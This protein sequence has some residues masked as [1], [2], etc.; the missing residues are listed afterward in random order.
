[1]AASFFAKRR[2]F[3]FILAAILSTHFLF[4]AVGR[5]FEETNEATPPQAAFDKTIAP[6][7][8]R[9]CLD[10]HNRSELAGGLD[11]SDREKALAGGDS[12][13]VLVPG[14]PA[15]SLLW[16]RIADGEMPPKTPLPPE[17]RALLKT[18]IAE[19]GRWGTNPI[20]PFRFTT[21]A[22]AGYDWWSLQPLVRPDVPRLQPKS[23]APESV[24][25]IDAFVRV[26]LAEH[27]LSPSAAADKR[28][29][30][31]RLSFDLLGLPP[32]PEETAAFLADDSADAYE[33]FVDRLLASP[34]YGQRWARHWLD[35]VRFG[36]SQG[37]ERDKLRPNAWRY[38]DW[39]VAAF[40]RDMPY[41]EF[42]RLQLAGDV[43]RPGD[44]DAII[45]T[46]FL[47]AGAFDEVGQRQQ[48]AAMKAVVRQDELEDILGT[49]GQTFLGLTV[50]CARCHD[51]KFDPISQQE[52]Y[53]MSAALAGVRHGE[54]KIDGAGLARDA[55]VR[56]AALQTRIETLNGRRAAITEPIR[57]RLLAERRERQK[58]VTPP[59]PI[60]RW[61]FDADLK[62]GIGELH[63]SAFGQARLKN[64][65]LLFDGTTGYVT[66]AP[67]TADLQEKTLETW[68]SLATLKQQGGGVMGVQTL[69]GNTFDSIVFGE[70]EPGRWMAGSNFFQRTKSFAGPEETV[71]EKQLVHLAIVYHADGT[72]AGYR[73]GQPYG[74]PYKSDGPIK[75]VA[76]QAQVVFGLRHSPA[77]GNRLLAGSIERAQ[78]YD[79]ALSADEVAASA[80]V[81]S[82]HV[83]EDAIVEQLSKSQ[84][85]EYDQLQFE[86]DQLRLQV[87]RVQA[88]KTYAVAPQPPEA[89]HVLKRGNPA[90]RGDEVVPGGI[91]AV[92]GPA[93]DFGLPADA[94]DDVR[95][96]E[97]ARWIT[98]AE[99]PLFARVIVNRIW[100]HHFGRGLVDSPSDF[101]FS[102]GRP[103]H[104]ELLDWLS[105]ELIRNG[106]SLKSLH[107][108]IVTS[109]TY[110]QSS[111]PNEAAHAVDADNRLLWRRSPQRLEAE[112]VRDAILSV[113]GKLDPAIGGPG[114]YDFT[115]F[116]H[117][118]QFYEPV[119]PVGESFNR[120]SLYRT[121]VRSGRN[122][123]LDAFD[124]P[125]PS[126]T[127]PKRAV[128]TTPLQALSL[129]NHAF[130]LRMSDR[131]A[132]RV[133]REV[134]EDFELQAARAFELV[135]ARPASQEERRVAAAFTSQH[136]LAALGR[137]LFNSNEFL[138][139]D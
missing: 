122:R 64:E 47:T 54:R 134:G 130:V 84:R 20:D 32:T 78:L 4:A 90:E 50:H 57:R 24:H 102:G 103:S 101:G 36:E 93:A 123:F 73:N 11:L 2:W 116:V 137:V 100:Q 139:V 72:I 45:A 75:F 30:L 21:D 13:P 97:L 115:T 44:A 40:N 112:A 28:T 61:Q 126:A 26:K 29:L 95:R 60:S 87:E 23:D 66:T 55:R 121:W 35:V 138:Y 82:D 88:M 3:V 41:D 108:M 39:I 6:L 18:W 53:G 27:G 92:P 48:S 136:G 70:Q 107:R 85:S 68:V 62:D 69:N 125:D 59:Q 71:A 5:A 117:N 9:R 81:A 42:A 22:R 105:V 86:V 106:W 96:I 67:L 14:E 15:E 98:D 58:H 89:T 7:L 120:R 16:Q 33:Q 127:A 37:F 19:G 80:G 17:E 133:T 135:Y 1:M 51:H 111:L 25:P 124:C 63:G 76:G 132:D 10:C 12:G 49:V 119:D 34:H 113:T 131:L 38:R 56:T 128:T 74:Q 91:A 129:M 109:A 43:L 99:N 114:Y 65:R 104:P 8:A 77:G 110:R 79:R 31:R 83:D 94:A 118:T 52:Y 46:G